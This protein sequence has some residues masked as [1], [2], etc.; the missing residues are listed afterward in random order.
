MPGAFFVVATPIGNLGDLTTR[1][2]DVLKR[3]DIVLAEDTRHSQRLFQGMNLNSDKKQFVS[4]HQHNEVNRVNWVLEALAEGRTLAL[5]SDAGTP[6]VSDP[7]GRLIEALAQRDVTIQ[8]CPG[9]SAIM[10]ALMGAGLNT[11][12]FAFLGFLP[13]KGKE[14]QDKI[15]ASLVAQLSVVLYEAPDRI[16]KTLEELHQTVGPLRVVVARELTKK[17]ETFH[18]G[19]LG[20][21]LKP[22]LVSKGEMVIVIQAPD[23]PLREWQLGLSEEAR[24]EKTDAWLEACL[25][26]EGRSVKELARELAA[27]TGWSRKKAYDAIITKKQQTF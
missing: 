13:K 17:F 19:I 6:T 8:V 3:A 4:C 14:R 12:Q 7:G 24:A 21:E 1:A 2:I 23:K 25:R 11:T 9:A 16:E 18:R 5:I 22:P 20:S 27:R 10:A 15:K 26:D